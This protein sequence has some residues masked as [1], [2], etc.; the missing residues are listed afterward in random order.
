VATDHPG[1]RVGVD[2]TGPLRVKKR[3]NRYIL[4]LVDHFTEWSEAVRIK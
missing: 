1:K 4:V 3:G 2:I